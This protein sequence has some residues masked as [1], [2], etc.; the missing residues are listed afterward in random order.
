MLVVFDYSKT[1]G[2]NYILNREFEKRLDNCETYSQVQYFEFII[3]SCIFTK[4]G[5]YSSTCWINY[6]TQMP[7][8][9]GKISRQARL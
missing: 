9:L 7:S 4:V 2:C 8:N 3:I 5:R 6:I 1:C